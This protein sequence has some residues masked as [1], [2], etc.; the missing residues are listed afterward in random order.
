MKNHPI[1]WISIAFSLTACGNSSTNELETSREASSLE[2]GVVIK[3]FV[4]IGNDSA[5]AKLERA[6]RSLKILKARSE[7]GSLKSQSINV[8]P[9]YYTQSQF[10][11]EYYSD[12]I[13]AEGM[14][15]INAVGSGE[16]TYEMYGDTYNA[17]SNCDPYYDPY[18]NVYYT[19]LAPRD[20]VAY[21][22][23]LESSISSQGIY[24]PDS[25]I[26][27]MKNIYQQTLNNF[28]YYR[29]ILYRDDILE[30]DADGCS[31]ILDTSDYR[32]FGPH[33]NR[34]DYGYRNY[35]LYRIFTLSNQD[36]I[37]GVLL[38]D[39]KTYC[40]NRFGSTPSFGRTACYADAYAIYGTLWYVAPVHPARL[41]GNP[42]TDEIEP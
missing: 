32:D 1:I 10:P 42:P 8:V 13:S 19:S 37:D 40:A 3:D 34:H 36:Y 23:K 26:L 33:C 39:M 29:N 17:Y 41:G 20:V 22:D 4:R 2:R 16:I 27:L 5:A 18:C 28:T 9:A 15:I 21:N 25:Q 38:T 24:H 14:A 35:Q 30:W 6:E 11:N 12:S 7:K 31:I